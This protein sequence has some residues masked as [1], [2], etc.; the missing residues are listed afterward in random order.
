MKLP[1][2]KFDFNRDTPGQTP[3][4]ITAQFKTQENSTDLTEPIN[5][6]TILNTIDKILGMLQTC[7]NVW[8]N[9][10]PAGYHPVPSDAYTKAKQAC[11]ETLK[12]IGKG[13][14]GWIACC[15]GSDPTVCTPRENCNTEGAGSTTIISPTD[16]YVKALNDYLTCL[17]NAR[18]N[19]PVS[20]TTDGKPGPIGPSGLDS[21][22][23]PGTMEQLVKRLNELTTAL[24]GCRKG[25]GDKL[26]Y[27]IPDGV[28]NNIP[29]PSSS[30]SL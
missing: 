11:I 30:R 3:E 22:C 18:K 16:E 29:L 4:L 7:N 24:S 19:T 12:K 25:L 17:N 9:W 15:N 8:E 21:P 2:T 14:Y 13:K 1:A 10:A 26:P 5:C 27:T 20:P 28:P 6:K 23:N